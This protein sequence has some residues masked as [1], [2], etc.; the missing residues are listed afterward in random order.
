MGTAIV[1]K[2]GENRQRRNRARQCHTQQPTQHW[3]LNA[4]ASLLPHGALPRVASYVGGGSTVPRRRPVSS[5]QRD[6]LGTC[7]LGGSAWR[8]L[9]ACH[10]ARY[11]GGGP[12]ASIPR[13]RRC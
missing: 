11:P 7:C 12:S 5:S 2:N 1:R 9:T 13:P 6:V 3:W 8:E 4:R 10:P